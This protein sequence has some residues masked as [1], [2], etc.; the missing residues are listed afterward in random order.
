MNRAMTTEDTK[1]TNS[2]DDNCLI[3]SEKQTT[4]P[5]TAKND[6]ENSEK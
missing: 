3:Q 6:T 5:R 2:G 4:T 1:T